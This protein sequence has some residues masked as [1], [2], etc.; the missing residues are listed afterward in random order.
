[1]SRFD[2]IAFDADD[3]LWHTERLYA[4][5]QAKLAHLLAQYHDAN[6]V[7]ERLYQTE[8]RNVEHFGYGVKAFTLSMVET[9]IEL[10]EGRIS[11]QDIGGLIEL[12]KKML[13]ADVE[14]LENVAATVEQVAAAYPVML[15]TKGDLFDQERKIARSGLASYFRHVEVV[16]DKTRDSYARLLQEHALDPRRFVMV[17]NSLRSDIL[18]ILE[19]GATAVYVPYRITWRHEAAEPPPPGQAGFFQLEHLGQLPALLARLEGEQGGL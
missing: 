15:I 10:T 12:G 7:E 9:A 3:T 14:L 8:M 1:M 5:A 13:T 2:M 4:E 11:A 6:W 18:P 19:L 17:G 16:S